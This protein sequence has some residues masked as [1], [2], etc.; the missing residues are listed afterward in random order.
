[1]AGKLTLTLEHI[2]P[3]H[4][5][6][7]AMAMTIGLLAQLIDLPAGGIKLTVVCEE[8]DMDSYVEDLQGVLAKR[9][10]GIRVKLK[11]ESEDEIERSTLA[12]VT[13]MD[14]AGWN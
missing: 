14:K 4:P 6:P 1:M 5:N 11:K 8:E 7:Q 2:D 9:P 13:P 12:S 10:V 3:K